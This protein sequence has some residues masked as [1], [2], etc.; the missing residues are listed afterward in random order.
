MIYPYGYPYI[1]RYD[2]TYDEFGTLRLT[3]GDTPQV[4]TEPLELADIKNYL[5]IDPEVNDN[6]YLITVFISAA[7][8]R[9]KSSKVAISSA[10]N[11]TSATTIGLSIVLH[12][13]LQPSLSI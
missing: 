10:S 1:S 7:V 12:C 4:F 13:V 8:S 9:Q 6:D 2:S 11:T 3:E 5:R